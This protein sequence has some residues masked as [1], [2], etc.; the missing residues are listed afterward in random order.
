MIVEFEKHIHL[1]NVIAEVDENEGMPATSVD[2][3]RNASKAD[4]IGLIRIT[5][6]RTGDQ[7]E[8][9][10]D[11]RSQVLDGLYTPVPLPEYD[12]LKS[13][14]EWGA[15]EERRA[16]TRQRLGAF[17]LSCYCRASTV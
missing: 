6:R 17:S 9:L 10:D 1:Q 2:P 7:S 3:Y 16:R 14:I 8:P 13:E 5:V 15:K 4:Q 12:A 11:E